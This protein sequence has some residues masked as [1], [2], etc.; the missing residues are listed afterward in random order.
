MDTDTHRREA[1]EDTAARG[2]R[3]CATEAETGV[4][5]LHVKECQGHLATTRAGSGWEGPELWKDTALSTP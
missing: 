1:C 4:R 5:R 3:S 2:R